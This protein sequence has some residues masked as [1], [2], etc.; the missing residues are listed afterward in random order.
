MKI[1][2]TPR[3][4]GKTDPDLFNRLEAAGLELIRNDTGHTLSRQDMEKLIEPCEGVILGVDPM[5]SQVL[6]RAPK[7]RVISR[8]G[9]GL[10]NIDLEE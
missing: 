6:A 4:F 8:Y 3:S 7:L 10:D 9:V 1:L 5:D 2:I